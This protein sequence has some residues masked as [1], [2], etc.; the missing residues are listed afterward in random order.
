[1]NTIELKPTARRIRRRPR[2]HLRRAA[3]ATAVTAVLASGAA[4][5]Q[6]EDL[7]GLNGGPFSVAYGVSADGSVVVGYADDGAAGNA[8]R[9]FRW[10]TEGGMVSLGVL[11]GG[12]YS[13]AR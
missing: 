10:T 7:G 3:L 8:G 13:Y 4:W 6:L 11:N 9:A 2:T 1:M 12:T 5:G